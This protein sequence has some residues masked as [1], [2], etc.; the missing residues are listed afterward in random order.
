MT[1]KKNG[2]EMLEPGYSKIHHFHRVTL[3]REKAF[4]LYTV[5][6]EGKHCEEYLGSIRADK[7]WAVLVAGLNEDLMVEVFEALTEMLLEHEV[8]YLQEL[9]ELANQD[10]QQCVYCLF[11]MRKL[12]DEPFFWEKEEGVD[13]SDGPLCASCY[14]ALETLKQDNKVSGID[15]D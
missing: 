13:G 6:N 1:D 11:P 8:D 15:K 5:D 3:V 9:E 7:D 12:T 2:A 14:S 10:M 4:I